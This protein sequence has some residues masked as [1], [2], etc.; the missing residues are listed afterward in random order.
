MKFCSHLVAEA[1]LSRSANSETLEAQLAL[2]P[3]LSLTQRID[4]IRFDSLKMEYVSESSLEDLFY[5]IN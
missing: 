1:C 5:F 4:K 2:Y 3:A